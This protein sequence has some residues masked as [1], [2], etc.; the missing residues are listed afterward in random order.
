MFYVFV[1]RRANHRYWKIYNLKYHNISRTDFMKPILLI[2][3]DLPWSTSI[4]NSSST[5]YIRQSSVLLWLQPQF[6][7]TS[8]CLLLPC[9]PFPLASALIPTLFLTL[10]R[11]SPFLASVTIQNFSGLSRHQKYWQTKTESI[12]HILAL[13]LNQ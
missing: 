7:L 1:I 12:C 8:L 3:W 4:F 5:Y 6:V 2:F 11:L 9:I 10:S 13:K